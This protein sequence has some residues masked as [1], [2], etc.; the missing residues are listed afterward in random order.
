MKLKIYNTM[1]RQ[2]EEFVPLMEDPNYNGPKKD[3]VGIYS[4]GPT[5]YRDPSIGNYR[6]TFTADLIR[7]TLKLFGY[8][9]I[10]VMNITDVGHLTSDADDGEDKLEKGAKREGI[11]V[12]EVA[13]K[14]ENIFMKGMKALNIDTFDVM[15]RATDHLAEQISLVQKLEEK[16][17]T[18]EVPGD[19]IYMDTSKVENYGKLMGPNYKKRLEDLNA[20][21]RV[22]MGGKRNPTDFALWKF[23]V[24]GQ[25]R[26]M[27][28]D[29]PRGIGFP[30]WHIECS[31]MSSKYL[32]EQFDIHH[33]GADHITVHHSNEIAQSECGFGVHPWVKY[34]VHNEFL[35]VDGGKMSKSLGNVYTLEDVQKRGYSPLDLKYFYFMAQYS[36]FQN[37]TWE[38]LDVAKNTRQALI[39]KLQG[40]EELKD[41][42]EF[43]NDPFFKEAMEAVSDNI[44]TP[45]LLAIIQSSLNNVNENTYAII[46]FFENNF[47]KLGLFEEQEEVEIPS[48]VQELAQKRREAKKNKDWN[49]ADSLRDQLTSLGWKILDRPDG[50]DLEKI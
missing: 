21:I 22:D 9:V 40:R 29:S 11:S 10:S 26:D 49:T 25:K 35:Q 37:F 41:R 4:C 34:W 47:L 28:R 17:Y 38:Q 15:P 36:N 7:N 12:W 39:R 42:K 43:E 14:Y 13:K 23:N 16:A 18:Y 8:K 19:G 31:A 20:G 30:G 45:K 33:G 50:F 5:V 3:F 2:K 1:S 46:T 44:N 48:E 6:A 24:T 32:G 27:E